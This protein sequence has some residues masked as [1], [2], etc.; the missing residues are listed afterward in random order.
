M[1]NTNTSF[2]VIEFSDGTKCYSGPTCKRHGAKQVRSNPLEDFNAKIA[3]LGSSQEE[4]LSFSNEIR[5]TIPSTRLDEA[6]KRIDIANRK[7][8]RAGIQDRFEYDVEKTIRTKDGVSVEF[9]TI[10]LNKPSISY[11]GW[12]FEAVHQFAA[13]GEIVSYYSDDATD[14][15]DEVANVCDHCGSNRHREKVYWVKDQNT[16]ER[17]QVG[18]GCLKAFFGI[19]PAGIWALTDDLKL[20]EM[21]EDPDKVFFDSRNRVYEAKELIIAA[22]NASENGESFISR[23]AAYG[24]QT[25]T[26]DLVLSNFDSYRAP[27]KET[28]ELA[29]QIMSFARN[30][31]ANNSYQEKLR[32]VLAKPSDGTTTYVKRAHLPLAVSAI[33]AWKNAAG[34]AETQAARDAVK[35]EKTLEKKSYLAPEG[36][37]VAN[38]PATVTKVRVLEPLYYGSKSS[39]LYLLKSEDGHVIKWTTSSDVDFKTGDKV[40][41][42]S[43]TVK[44]NEIYNEDTYQTVIL[45]PK[46]ELRSRTVSESEAND[47][48][49]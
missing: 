27:T 26:A 8:E 12:D 44:K 11:D 41:I 6:L 9:S 34:Y 14:R 46:I 17:K 15:P 38:I 13:N 19:K 47:E 24:N 10:S 29:E 39:N 4:D 40:M 48:N 36:E 2:K 35:Q 18:S 23:S 16:G 3:N 5:I 45:R 30:M 33:S 32:A 43:A 25:P 28:A 37:K 1:S 21:A 49:S 20:G 7:L 22:L 31:P 42:N